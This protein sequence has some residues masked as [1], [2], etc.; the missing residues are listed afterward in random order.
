MQIANQPKVLFW[1]VT[2]LQPGAKMVNVNFAQIRSQER[3]VQLVY[4]T[5]AYIFIFLHRQKFSLNFLDT[6]CTICPQKR[7]F[8]YKN[9]QFLRPIR[10]SGKV[11]IFQGFFMIKTG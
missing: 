5:C 2:C 9:V 1:I 3:I 10:G 6:K 4:D 11:N 8:L 7:Q